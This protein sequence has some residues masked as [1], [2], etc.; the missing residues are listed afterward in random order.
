MTKS[1]KPREGLPTGSGTSPTRD[2]SDPHPANEEHYDRQKHP[3]GARPP[4]QHIGPND[5]KHDGRPAPRPRNAEN[6]GRIRR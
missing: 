1:S 2:V 4:K 6:E 3:G 5:A